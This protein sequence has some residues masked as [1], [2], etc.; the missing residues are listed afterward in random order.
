MRCLVLGSEVAKKLKI[1]P[2]VSTE[3]DSCYYSCKENRGCSV[4][5][6]LKMFIRLLFGVVQN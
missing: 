2:L 6:V 1:L 5:L 3:K 4:D